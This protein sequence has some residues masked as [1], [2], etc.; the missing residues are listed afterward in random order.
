MPKNTT[1]RFLNLR[2]LQVINQLIVCSFLHKDLALT[3]SLVRA[4]SLDVMDRS[5]RI[6]LAV[7]GCMWS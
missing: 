3:L 1:L 5:L 7:N 6:T 4:L 2:N